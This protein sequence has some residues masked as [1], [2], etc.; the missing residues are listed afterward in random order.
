MTWKQ[1]FGF[2]GSV[3][4]GGQGS[5]MY[6]NAQRG[7]NDFF[8]EPSTPP[9]NSR[10][11]NG[12]DSPNELSPGLL[13]LHSFD[14]ELIPEVGLWHFNEREKKTAFCLVGFIKCLLCL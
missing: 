14:T 13:D 10:T 9:S 2:Y 1:D 5:R 3:G 4:G 7:F 6:R 12:D 8:M 11:K